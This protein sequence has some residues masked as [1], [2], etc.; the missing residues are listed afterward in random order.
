[1]GQEK[2]T[3][4]PKDREKHVG[5]ARFI[6]VAGTFGTEVLIPGPLTAG[7]P[8]PE[9]EE[10]WTLAPSRRDDSAASADDPAAEP[11]PV[12]PVKGKVARPP[13]ENGKPDPV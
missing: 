13:A 8:K 11:A 6:P 3:G 10:R 12:E 4:D 9:P 5:S 1:M 7:R 2:R